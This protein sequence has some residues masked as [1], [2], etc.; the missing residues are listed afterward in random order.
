MNPFCVCS[1]WLAWA[2]GCAAEPQDPPKQESSKQDPGKQDSGKQDPKAG[3][4][5]DSAADKVLAELRAELHKQGIEVDPKAQ[6]VT[7][8]CTMNEPRD[9]VEYVLIH[10]R[11]KRHEAVLV[12]E[13][14]PSMLNA[15]L[16]MLGFEPG[17]NAIATEKEPRP[18]LEEIEAGVDPVIVTPPEGMEFWMTVRWQGAD[19]KPV[20]Y[21]IE[22]LL[23][24]LST[25]LPLEQTAWIFLGGRMAALYRNEPEVYVAD[26]EGNLV[27]ACYM[28]PENHLGT[29]KHER[30][31]DDQNVWLTDKCPEPGTRMQLV[32]H[33]Q[34]PKLVVDREARLAVE[35]AAR[36]K[37]AAEAAGKDKPPVEPGK[38]PGKEPAKESGR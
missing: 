22:D 2:V 35:A 9:P 15:A 7:I 31:R 13:T 21:C 11:G 5:A 32:F 20:E 6:T 33:R 12:T 19:D 3:A 8:A 1:L 23:L 37:A 26:F 18:T 38:E 24:D 28:S 10:A 17:K 14:K 16:L 27:S 34:K 29:L 36:A 30:A 25:Q 4:S